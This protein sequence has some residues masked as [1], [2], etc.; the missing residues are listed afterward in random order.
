MTILN[1]RQELDWAVKLAGD[2]AAF[3][4]NSVPALE[5]NYNNLQ[6][7]LADADLLVNATSVGMSPDDNQTPVD[8]SLLRPGLAV[9]DVVYNPLTTRLLADA[10]AAG[11]TAIGGIGML[12]GQGALAFELW[13]GVEPPLEV[14]QKAAVTTL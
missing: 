9:F 3:C 13:T 6:A 7:A 11:A 4:G 14:M 12:V 8:K 2:A 1:R 5:L 10:E